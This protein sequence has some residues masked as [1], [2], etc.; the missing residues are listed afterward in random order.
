MIVGILRYL[1][2]LAASILIVAGYA[3]SQSQALDGQIE[4]TVTDQNGAA[5]VGARISATNIGTGA[6]RVTVTD[7]SGIYRIPLL[8]LGTYRVVADAPN[9]RTEVR[10]GLKIVTGHTATIDLTLTAGEPHESVT[11]TADAPIADAGKTDLGRVMNTREVENLPLITLN[12]YNFGLLQSNVNG[13]LSRGFAFPSFNVNGYLRR[14]NYQLDGNTNTTYNGRNRF[15]LISDGYPSEIQLVTNGFA[16]E[17]GDTPGM[18][19]NIVTPSGTNAFSGAVSYRF[20]RP[21]FYS[22]PFF[23]DSPEDI[24]DN[25]ANNFTGSVGGP[26]IKD[27]WHFFG[28]FQS[29][30]RDDRA[31]AGRR[32]TITPANREALIAAGLSPSIFPPAMPATEKGSFFIF[33]SDVQLNES[34][35]LAVR[36]NHADVN[37]PYFNA[38]GLNT[39]ERGINSSSIDH[40]VGTQLTSYTRE[41][42]NEFR[43]SYGRRASGNK[44]NA[45]SGTDPSI[46]ITG[47]ANFGSPLNVQTGKQVLTI[48]QF[49][50]NLTHATGSH[51]VKFGGGFSFHDYEEPGGIL[52]LYRFSSI[53]NYIAARNGSNPRSYSQYRQSFGDPTI[54]YKATFWNFFVQDDWKVTPRL[55]VNVGLRYD[56]YRIPKA[57]PASPFPLSRKFDADAND[58]APRLGIVYALREGSRPTVIRLGAGIYYE[59]PLLAIHRDVLRFNG[60]AR[61]VSLTFNAATPGA[62]DFPNTLGAM[63]PGSVVPRQDIY[64]IAE[65]CDTMYAI[66]S[67]VQFE[68]AITEGLSL[69]VGYVH[70]AGRH[71]NVYRN[72]NPISPVSFL[73]DGRPVFG[74]ERLDPRFGWIVNAESAGVASYDALALQLTQRMTRG[75]QFSASYTLSK[76]TNDAPDGDIEGTFL[77]DPTDRSVDM[78]NSSAD[79]RHTFVMSLVAQPQFQ[80][81]KRILRYLLNH[82]QVGIIATANSGNRFN[83]VS[84]DDLNGDSFFSDRPVGLLRNSGKTPPQFNVDLR[85]SRFFNFTERYRLEL[86]GEFQ[87]LFN[88]NSILGFSDTTVSTDPLTGYMIGPLPDFRTQNSSIAQESRQLQIGLKFLF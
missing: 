62:P 39:L 65:D 43:F 49:Q 15:L 4:G 14:V 40:A 13:S 10:E 80:V 29:Q 70:S 37:T 16:A 63:P 64:T 12:P 19:M 21:S 58:I 59:A 7:A 41:I 79:Q 25:K 57:D 18:I 55:K 52:R 34:N 45:T 17:F 1:V 32:I 76:A 9:F 6:A 82:N 20:R 84:R 72:I 44:L 42:F 33:R 68:Q 24:P 26:L 54:M 3:F 56:I 5:V 11:I 48:T 46:V 38:G 66:H 77:S 51:V 36:F 74:S 35:R 61:F 67:N 23:Y 30:Y 86:F 2:A 71:L 50:D 83:I 27:R 88:T 22:R 60:N 28:S 78:G 47:V 8:P 87:N 69:A 53:A 81:E 31:S 73:A 75:I 85:Y